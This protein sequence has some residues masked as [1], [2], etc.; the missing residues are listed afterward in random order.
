[1]QIDFGVLLTIGVYLVGIGLWSGKM[2]MTVMAQ[3][4]RLRQIEDA[5]D[6]RIMKVESRIE[7]TTDTLARILSELT[8]LTTLIEERTSK[9]KTQ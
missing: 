4:E 3:G 2:H 9:N 7:S 6:A 5:H 8:R 1:M